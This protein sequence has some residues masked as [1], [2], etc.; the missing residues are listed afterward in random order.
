MRGEYVIFNED[1]AEIL[2]VPNTLVKEGQQQLMNA[3]FNRDDISG[4]NFKFGVFSE[5]PNYTTVFAD[6]YATEPVGNGYARQSVAA[7]GWT[8]VAQNT[9]VYAQSPSVTFTAAG[10]NYDKTFNRFFMIARVEDPAATFTEYLASYSSAL[11][12][13]VQLLDTQTYT[14][15]YRV[16][17]K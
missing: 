1:G 3:L 4:L 17:M 9:E 10:G 13:A 12:A 14:L 7:S 11:A 6:P 16:F 5:V 2:V 15:A 8:I